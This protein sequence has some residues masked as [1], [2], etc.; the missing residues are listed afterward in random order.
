M[1]DLGTPVIAQ[2]LSQ[3]DGLITGSPACYK[4]LTFLRKIAS[5]IEAV[6]VDELQKVVPAVLQPDLLV[7]R[8]ARRI[9][10]GFVLV[11]NRLEVV[12]WCHVVNRLPGLL[13][14][15][16]SFPAA[17]SRHARGRPARAASQG[18]TTGVAMAR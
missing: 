7:C 12:G 17:R 6:E 9:G 3:E 16:M 2:L 10:K 8:V 14:S 18:S 15:L 4:Y 1:H 11:S 13:F 5:P